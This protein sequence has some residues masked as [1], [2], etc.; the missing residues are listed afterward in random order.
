MV[1]KEEG[2]E[3]HSKIVQ[4]FNQC[5]NKRKFPEAWCNAIVILLYKK[6]DKKGVGSY[7]P[8]SL[9]SVIYKLFSNVLTNKLDSI[10]DEN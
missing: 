1:L 5:L 7:C 8:I 4:L 6:G 9:Q 3:V 10:R 2:T